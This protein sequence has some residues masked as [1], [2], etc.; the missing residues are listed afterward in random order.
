[1]LPNLAIT[2]AVVTCDI[3]SPAS[4]YPSNG[5]LTNFATEEIKLANASL[6]IVN[7]FPAPVSRAPLMMSSI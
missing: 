2:E 1:M 6:I 5:A 3:N 4:L 7:T